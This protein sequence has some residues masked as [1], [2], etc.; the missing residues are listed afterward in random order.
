MRTTINVL[1]K[2]TAWVLNE[3]PAF[4]AADL[5]Q[6]D[7]SKSQF[8]LAQRILTGGC[9]IAS[10]EEAIEF[11]S[12]REKRLAT[13]NQNENCFPYCSSGWYEPEPESVSFWYETTSGTKLVASFSGSTSPESK[14]VVYLPQHRQRGYH[15]Q[16][17]DAIA[18]GMSAEQYDRWYNSA[19]ESDLSAYQEYVDWHKK[20]IVPLGY[21][22][23]LESEELR[24]RRAARSRARRA[25]YEVEDYEVE[26]Y[27]VE[28]Y[29]EELCL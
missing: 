11:L 8:E 5:I 23:M 21:A 28:D 16:L 2:E 29:E 6:Y 22:P 14:F 13:L 19:L 26:D 9:N 3:P 4:D 25:D 1:K 18:C 7:L 27:E 10:I 17:L 15:N 24:S 12:A 20:F